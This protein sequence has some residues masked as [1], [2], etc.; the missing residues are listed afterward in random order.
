MVYLQVPSDLRKKPVISTYDWLTFNGLALVA[1]CREGTG[2]VDPGSAL[3]S[4]F[5]SLFERMNQGIRFK[6]FPEQ[7]DRA[8][9]CGLC[10]QP[11]L[12]APGNHDG[13]HS[14][15]L[16]LKLPNEVKSAHA[17]HMKVGD[18]TV[19]RSRPVSGVKFL[20]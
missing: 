15:A 20:H 1:S 12:R 11:W 17:G 10:F 7:A 2:S 8:N 16:R 6:W 14:G 3:R 4:D 19:A 5:E 13:R 18:D 9:G